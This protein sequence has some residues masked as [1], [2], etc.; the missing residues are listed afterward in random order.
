[1]LLV[2]G[3][4]RNEALLTADVQAARR[5]ARVTEAEAASS[6]G[7]LLSELIDAGRFPALTRLIAAGVFDGPLQPDADFDFGLERILDGIAVLADRR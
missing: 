6:Y 4:V 5:A 1:M 7:R 3:F 2:N